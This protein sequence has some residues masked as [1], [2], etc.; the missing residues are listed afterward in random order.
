MGNHQI[1][2]YRRMPENEQEQPQPDIDGISVE[3]RREMLLKAWEVGYGFANEW[4]AFAKRNRDFI[5]AYPA[6]MEFSWA[7]FSPK[8][9]YTITNADQVIAFSLLGLA[10]EDFQHILCLA[11]NAYGSAAQARVRTMFERVIL[12]AYFIKFPAQAEPY[13]KSFGSIALIMG[14]RFQNQPPHRM[15]GRT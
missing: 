1:C 9:R 4:S 13:C 8:K 6:L 7:V 14:G 15:S 5:D 2:Q 10:Q 11:V 12:A 3:I